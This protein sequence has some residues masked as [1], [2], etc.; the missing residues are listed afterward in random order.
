M[1]NCF[2]SLIF[3]E[4]LLV[5]M[6]FSSKTRNYIEVFN[7]LTILGMSYGIFYITDW[8]PEPQHKYNAGT[9]MIFLVSINIAFNSM[10]VLLNLTKVLIKQRRKR[11]YYKMLEHHKAIIL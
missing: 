7:E 9:C 8:I 4:L 1:I 11:Q 5:S 10:I 3:V 2:L 6:P